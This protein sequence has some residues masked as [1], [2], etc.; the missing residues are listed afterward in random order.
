MAVLKTLTCSTIS[1]TATIATQKQYI[2]PAEKVISPSK[3]NSFKG[4]GI[5]TSQVVENEIVRVTLNFSGYMT[6]HSLSIESLIAIREAVQATRQS[7]NID[8][9]YRMLCPSKFSF[10]KRDVYPSVKVTLENGTVA[11]IP[12]DLVSAGSLL[13]KI[14]APNDVPSAVY[15]LS[16]IDGYRVED[17]GKEMQ[18]GCQYYDYDNLLTFLDDAITATRTAIS[19][20]NKTTDEDNSE[21]DQS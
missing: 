20:L 9:C 1:L 5:D 16:Q 8:D 12:G 19:N 15:R 4:L 3:L 11:I 2:S 7:T 10:Q 18:V 17:R 14:L 6:F 21:E 13:K